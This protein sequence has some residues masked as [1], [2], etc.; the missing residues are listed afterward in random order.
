MLYSC[1][2]RDRTLLAPQRDETGEDGS[3]IETSRIA[4]AISPGG[5]MTGMMNTVA[6]RVTSNTVMLLAGSNGGAGAGV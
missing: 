2:R 6:T 5:K 1:Q 4:R 3:R